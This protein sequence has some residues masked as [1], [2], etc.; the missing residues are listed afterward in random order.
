MFFFFF[1]KDCDIG[2]T[3]SGGGLYLGLCET[4]QCNQHSSECDPESG[5]CRVSQT[6]QCNQHCSECVPGSGVCRVSQTCQCNQHCSECVPESG[7]CR[8]S[9]AQF[10]NHLT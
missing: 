9:Q 2:Y 3:R 6:C 8:V 1:I 4:C 5:V 7:V 10:F